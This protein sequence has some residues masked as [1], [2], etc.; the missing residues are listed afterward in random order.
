M[1]ELTGRHE[2]I[3][4]VKCVKRGSAAAPLLPSS[5]FSCP[6]GP[7]LRVCESNLVQALQGT[8]AILCINTGDLKTMTL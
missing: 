5:A 2:G 3:E 6:D 8:I 7:D 4:V 1:T